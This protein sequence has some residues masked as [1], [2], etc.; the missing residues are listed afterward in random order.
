M[1]KLDHVSELV[2]NHL[3]L[4][5]IATVVVIGF[6]YISH[7]Y[8][9]NRT[10]KTLEQW[11]NNNEISTFLSAA[12]FSDFY[13]KKG[14]RRI[15]NQESKQTKILAGYLGIKPHK[16]SNHILEVLHLYYVF[17]LVK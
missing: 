6:V 2:V 17:K 5:S 9:I 14:K 15:I 13:L 11:L 8:Q 10:V 12:N 4:I 3:G 1:I 16:I 7:K